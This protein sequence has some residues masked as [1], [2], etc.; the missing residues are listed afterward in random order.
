MVIRHA[1]PCPH[2]IPISSCLYPCLMP[3][4]DI[5]V[6]SSPFLSLH[7]IPSMHFDFPLVYI[8]LYHHSIS[9]LPCIHSPTLH[10]VSMKPAIHSSFTCP[11]SNS[12][13]SIP[14]PMLLLVFVNLTHAL[15]THQIYSSHMHHFPLTAV[16]SQCWKIVIYVWKHG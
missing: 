1:P 15:H 6:F 8:T 2:L 13:I 9:S 11:P 10:A 3:S 4:C 5:P 16:L 7:H 14:I 12:L